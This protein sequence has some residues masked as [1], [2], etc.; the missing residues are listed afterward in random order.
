MPQVQLNGQTIQFEDT[1][2]PGLPVLFS[3]G[4]LMDQE[5]FAAQR[6][7]LRGEFRVISWDQRGF[8]RSEFDGQPFTYWDSA[9]D[10]LALLDHLQ[11]ERAVLA[12]MSQGGYLSLRAALLA[13]QRVQAL[14][15]IDTQAGPEHEDK[16]AAYRQ[17][18]DTWASVGPVDALAQTIATII[19]DDPAENARWIAKWR[20]RP[21][22]TIR[23]PGRCL[24]ERDDL[25]PRLSEIRCPA[26]VIH[27]SRDTAI[28]PAQAQALREGLPRGEGVVL[29]EGAAHAANLTHPQAVNLPLLA[30]LRRIAAAGPAL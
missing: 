16:R 29:I 5:M 11:I 13:P 9:R 15:L 4:F 27:G 23:E 18:L 24:L 12:G 20:A 22:A 21:H 26:L 10:A 8:G 1:G 2:G 6:E 3:H 7:A 30:F 14:V 28:E 17:L 25:R 19:I